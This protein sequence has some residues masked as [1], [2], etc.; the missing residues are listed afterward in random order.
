MTM[1]RPGPITITRR[2]LKP[3]PKPKPPASWALLGASKLG[4]ASPFRAPCFPLR[5]IPPSH[6]IYLPPS[7][8]ICPSSLLH[9]LLYSL[10]PQSICW[11]QHP[12]LFRI[13]KNTPLL[14][15]NP[16][17]VWPSVSLR[18]QLLFFLPYSYSPASLNP[19][20]SFVIHYPTTPP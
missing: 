2:V 8:P 11:N 18:P 3:K 7:L 6:Y 14:L 15:Y 13:L 1:R 17:N 20:L 10:H 5:C 4:R 16:H 12:L 19:S 9:S